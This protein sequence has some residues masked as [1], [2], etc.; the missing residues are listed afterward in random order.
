MIWLLV[1]AASPVCTPPGPATAVKVSFK[2]GSTVDDVARFATATLCEPWNVPPSAA[3]RALTLSVE[4]EVAGRQLPELFRLL[5]GIDRSEVSPAAT[6][7]DPKLV[8]SIVPL[9]PWTRKIP[10][11]SRDEVVAC[12][13]SQLRI[14]PAVR[15][16][17]AQGFTLFG[18]R[19][20]SLGEALAFQNG[21]VVLSVNG[22]QLSSASLALEA[23]TAHKD[24]QQLKL[25]IIRKGEQRTITWQI[26]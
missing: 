15:E 1:L 3:G 14:V 23:Y 16:G 25:A 19:P 2:A 6:V 8:A 13:P 18:I 24:A 11:A 12:A 4:G 9:D 21:D 7:C 10:A 22:S 20:G 17:R 26:R 5:T